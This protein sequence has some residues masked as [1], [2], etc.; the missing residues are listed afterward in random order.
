M[1][2]A[3][4][5]EVFFV[6]KKATKVGGKDGLEYIDTR[7]IH[8]SRPSLEQQIPCKHERVLRAGFS[9]LSPR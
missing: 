3:S 7:Q 4:R 8:S 6:E 2:R 5:I 1:Q 9:K